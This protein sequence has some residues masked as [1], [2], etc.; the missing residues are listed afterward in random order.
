M[1]SKQ[2]A[3]EPVHTMYQNLHLLKSQNN[4]GNKQKKSLN[5]ITFTEQDNGEE[6][7]EM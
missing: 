3:L 2:L 5:H 6:L 1:L 7:W 4:T